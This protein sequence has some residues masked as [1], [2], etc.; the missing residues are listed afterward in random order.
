MATHP[1]PHNST[2]FPDTPFIPYTDVVLR[3]LSMHFKDTPYTLTP[4]PLSDEHVD[5]VMDST[6]VS[7]PVES[8]ASTSNEPST[9]SSH[10]PNQPLNPFPSISRPASPGGDVEMF[11]AEE[12]SPNDHEMDDSPPTLS[13][14][15]QNT[16]LQD[17]LQELDLD[18]CSTHSDGLTDDEEDESGVVEEIVVERNSDT[19]ETA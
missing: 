18:G 14:T 19:D 4:P 17:A 9:T 5:M 13:A 2:D 7:P 11:P 1:S 8:H 6:E 3:L 12:I 15:G 16:P 10:L